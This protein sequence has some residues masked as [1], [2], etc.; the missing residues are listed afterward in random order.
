[1][2]PIIDVQRF[3]DGDAQTRQDIADVIARSCEAI[4]FLYAVNHAVSP[5]TIEATKTALRRFFANPPE[6]KRKVERP[7]GRYRGYIP[8]SSFSEDGE[9]RPLV[10][11]ESFLQGLPISAGDARI[12]E[13][14]GLLWPNLWPE[15]AGQEAFRQAAQS[16]WTAV[17]ALSRDLLQAFSL[18]LG[19]PQEGLL[20]H[21]E[22]QLS[23]ISYLHYPPRPQLRGGG[24]APPA[25]K[26]HYDTNSLTVLLPDPMGGLQVRRK[27][28]S[29]AEVEPLEG[30]FIVNIGN[31]MEAW[32]GGRF[33][34][35]MHRVNPPPGVERYS[36]GFFAVPGY[37][38]VV[39][40]LAGAAEDPGARF[41][42]PLH[43]GGDLARFVASCDAMSQA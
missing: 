21:F 3:R 15:G 16:Y 37:D 13:T 40:P 5:V 19:L 29:W 41:S 33:K 26:A 4:G 42:K 23:N 28:G 7:R 6:E 36:I 12:K 2:L 43:V 24:G 8:L 22:N 27:D 10:L 17:D 32:S 25:P 18:A 20:H 14:A 39:R 9:G 11:Y 38:T 31:M 1:M 30:A 34:S 35:T